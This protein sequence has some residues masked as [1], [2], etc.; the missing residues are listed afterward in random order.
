MPSTMRHGYKAFPVLALVSVMV[1][2]LL[3]L[4]SLFF[5]VDPIYDGIFPGDDDYYHPGNDE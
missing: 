4:G 5:A 1:A 3:P 2:L